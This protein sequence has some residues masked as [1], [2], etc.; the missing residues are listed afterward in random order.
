MNSHYID[1]HIHLDLIKSRTVLDFINR[2]KIYTIAVTNHPK[3]FE[4]FCSQV[5]SP[6]IRVA[7]GMHPQLLNY[8]DLEQF[9]KHLCETKYIGEVGI[10][11][12]DR[13]LSD[14]KKVKQI[15]TF[16]QI[17]RLSQNKILSIHSRKAENIVINCIEKNFNTTSIYILHWYTGSLSNLQKACNIGCYFSVNLDLVCSKHFCDYVK[18]IP[19]ER[20]LT[21]T[22][23]PFA[24]QGGTDKIKFLVEKLSALYNMDKQSVKDQIFIN[25]RNI[26]NHIE[27]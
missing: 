2:Y 23:A 14:E 5:D 19:I 20:I 11:F 1:C 27:R 15:T 25:F 3:V 6:Y 22:D 4:R 8:I 7:L 16:E 12:S 21:E 10:D 17:L 18:I 13:T 9:K 26:L 24:K